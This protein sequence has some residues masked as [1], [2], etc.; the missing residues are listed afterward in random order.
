MACTN[1][2]CDSQDNCSCDPCEC[3]PTV[4]CGCTEYSTVAEHDSENE[5][6]YPDDRQL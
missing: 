3:S 4:Q 1:E 2:Y 5:P 6:L